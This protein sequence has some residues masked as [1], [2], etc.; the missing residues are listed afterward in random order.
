MRNE[1]DVFMEC[2]KRPE[3]NVLAYLF[4]HGTA[5]SR[6]IEHDMNLRQPEVSLAIS[7][8]LKKKWIK[9][10]EIKHDGK[11]RPNIEY[12]LAIDNKK[13]ILELK[14]EINDKLKSLYNTLNELDNLEE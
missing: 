1:V 10:R 5:F 14:K 11:G 9:K 4:R 3:A 6:D 12:H 7:A 2:L 13:I 8:F